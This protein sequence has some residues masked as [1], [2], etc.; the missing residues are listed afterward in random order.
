MSAQPDE[1][2]AIFDALDEARQKEL[3]DY[4]QELMD[5]QPTAKV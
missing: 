1:L 3:A 2:K 4:A 5:E